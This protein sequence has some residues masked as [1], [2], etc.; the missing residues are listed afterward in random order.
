M[1]TIIRQEQNDAFAEAHY[2]G[3]ESRAIKHLMKFFPAHLSR[4]SEDEKRALVAQIVSRA[5]KYGLESEQAVMCYA[6]LPLLL[7]NDFESNR[8]YQFAPRI[9]TTQCGHP[10]ERAKL[11]ML[12]AYEFKKR[13]L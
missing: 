3:F 4:L 9:L 8:R 11:A 10:I 13:G 2:R 1:T 5:R 6:H 7:G 12:L